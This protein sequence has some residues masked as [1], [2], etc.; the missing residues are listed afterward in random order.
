MLMS[1][2]DIDGKFDDGQ[3]VTSDFDMTCPAVENDGVNTR[4]VNLML[5]E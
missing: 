5:T 4:K 1:M 2:A 3:D